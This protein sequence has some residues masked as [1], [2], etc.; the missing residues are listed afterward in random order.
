MKPTATKTAHAILMREHGPS[1]V[2]TYAEVPF[3]PL[4]PTRFGSGASRRPST[5]PTSR[6]EPEIGR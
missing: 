3:S 4:A 6:S 2:L 1:D 5:T